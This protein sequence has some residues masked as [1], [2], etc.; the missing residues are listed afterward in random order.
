MHEDLVSLVEGVSRT[1][2]IRVDANAL[3]VHHGCSRTASHSV[4]VAGEA[5]RLARR[6]GECPND[7]ELAGLLHD[8]SAVVPAGKRLALAEGSGIEVVAEERQFPMIIHQKLSAAMAV[9]LF[10]V[11]SAEVISAIGCHTTL[12]A[13]ASKLDKIV[14]VADKISWDQP[15]TPP[16]L[17]EILKAADHSI[18]RAAYVYLRYLWSIRD[19]LP[20]LHPWVEQAYR[21]LAGL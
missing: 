13:G 5:K 14:F 1:G 10:A 16:Y 4:D 9:E 17:A 6:W 18:D 21:Q 7:A 12:K 2:N 20:V 11:K 8:I 3:L 19:E 15:G